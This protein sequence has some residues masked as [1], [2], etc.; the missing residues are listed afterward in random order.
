MKHRGAGEDAIGQ[1]KPEA[2]DF[3]ELINIYPKRRKDDSLTLRC[4]TIA[5][6]SGAGL[7]QTGNPPL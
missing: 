6:R 4:K 1:G 7:K 3:P 5:K 2:F